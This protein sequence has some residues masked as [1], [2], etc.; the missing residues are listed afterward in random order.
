MLQL[1]GSRQCGTDDKNGN[2]NAVVR[3]YHQSVIP[4]TKKP[5]TRM[6]SLRS[7][8]KCGSGPDVRRRQ[9]PD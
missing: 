9:S 5:Q 4:K 8:V 6:R 7:E 2:S 3:L 1:L